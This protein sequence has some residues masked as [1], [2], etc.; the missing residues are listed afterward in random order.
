MSS[1][2]PNEYPGKTFVPYEGDMPVETV[3]VSADYREDREG[4]ATVERARHYAVL[5]DESPMIYVSRIALPQT[6]EGSSPS[7]AEETS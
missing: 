3:E 2:N 6:V 5:R 4:I 1:P 7:S